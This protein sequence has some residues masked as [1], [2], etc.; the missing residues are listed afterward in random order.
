MPDSLIET[1]KARENGEGIQEL[2][3][4]D[5]VPGETVR[6]SHGPFEGYTAIFQARTGK[7]R[8]ALL[9]QIAEQSVRLEAD[10]SAIERY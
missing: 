3:S 2:P 9:L 6:I 4:L 1:L 7:E 5:P 8:V 10:S